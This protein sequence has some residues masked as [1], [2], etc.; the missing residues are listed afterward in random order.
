MTNEVRVKTS[1]PG[2]KGASSEIDRLRDRFI[3]L[4]KQGA[5]GFA[6]G[7][8][9]AITAKGI[10]LLG[11]ALDDLKGFAE[12]SIRAASDLNETVNKSAVVFGKSASVVEDFGDRAA[13]S[14]GMSKQ[15]AMEAAATFGNLFESMG[16]GR[17]E[18]AG[19]SVSMVKL[20]GDLASFNNLDP[21][22]TLQKLQSGIVGET[23]AVRD[24]GID[25][26]ETTVSQELMRE[27]QQKVGGE[28]TNG[29]KIMARYRLIL[30]QTKNA[31]GDFKRTADGAANS[32][33]ILNAEIEDSKAKLGT[34][35]LPLEKE[36]L[37]DQLAVTSVVNDLS[38]LLDRKYV[39][40][41]ERVA[42]SLKSASDFLGLFGH[43][44]AVVQPAI[45][46]LAEGAKRSDAAIA[47][48]A[49]HGIDHATDELAGV[50]APADKAAGAI[51][52]VGS[53]A[54]YASGTSSDL[55][56]ALDR[57]AEAAG[58]ADDS[59]RTLEDDLF[60]AQQRSGDLAQAQDD[61]A[62]LLKKPPKEGTRE[63]RIWNGKAAEARQRIFDLQYQMKQAEG[64]KALYDW[65][66]KQRDSL[67]KNTKQWY[68][69]N[70]LIAQTALLLGQMPR[71][72]VTLRLGG[73]GP[74]ANKFIPGAAEGAYIKARPG[75]TLVNVGEGGKDEAIIPLGKGP[76]AGAVAVGSGGSPVININVS[77]PIATPGA[78]QELARLIVP[79]ITRELQRNG[80]LSR[81]G[82][83]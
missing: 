16:L 44:L 1:A 64:P 57:I 14:V 62:T 29:Q 77:T 30:E 15:A 3:A 26:S 33:R 20:A 59:L 13:K 65:L 37:K 45:D 78:M 36:W 9:A 83:F 54:D 2:A 79:V 60:G 63:W 71:A 80:H 38:D 68:D 48:M 74:L 82:A 4:Q 35:L 18:A 81:A 27:G 25:I 7:A 69:L 55:A 8:G 53:A 73:T 12:D 32:Q 42:D 17:D 11:G 51:G 41:N 58:K 23:K 50:R 34:R 10:G 21:T 47:D 49:D 22:E 52:H 28:Y 6:I 66:N 43:G 40:S 67:K 75:G 56:G 5:K 31:Q 76:T 39:P 24:L 70:T 46:A 61:L 19:L 72:L